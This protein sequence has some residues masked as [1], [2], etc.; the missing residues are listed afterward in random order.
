LLP[1]LTG[2]LTGGLVV[3]VSSP[4]VASRR[5]ILAGA[6]ARAGV[7]ADDKALDLLAEDLEV[8]A[9]ELV[10]TLATL[11]AHARHDRKK[12]DTAYVR[13][14]LERRADE[15]APSLRAIGEQA[16]RRFGLKLSDLKSN[17]RR[18]S[19][20]MA[21]DAAVFLARRLTNKSLQEVG[22]FFG[23]RDHTTIMH[24]CRK[25]EDAV[26]RDAETREMLE[27]IRSRLFKN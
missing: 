3:S 16:A 22:A 2:R 26:G 9:A 15:T 19:V 12:L 10:G 21:R 27:S 18:R 5:A 4:S 17:S 14:Y 1:G 20:V 24:S 13:R 6:A 8:T 25:L 11:S 7:H 23:G